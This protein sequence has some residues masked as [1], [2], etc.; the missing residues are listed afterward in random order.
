[1]RANQQSRPIH[2]A[3]GPGLVAAGIR[4]RAQAACVVHNRRVQKHM[5][6]EQQLLDI[7]LAADRARRITIQYREASRFLNQRR[8]EGLMHVP[9]VR[10][11]AEQAVI[12]RVHLLLQPPGKMRAAT[13]ASS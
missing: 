1:M 13:A 6:L 4:A 10:G 11:T 7:G 12:D 5:E 3:R 9:D 8:M 2:R